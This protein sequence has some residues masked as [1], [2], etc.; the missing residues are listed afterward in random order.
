MN[1]ANN[2]ELF[3]LFERIAR[4][5]CDIRTLRTRG[6]DSLDFHDVSV[7]ALLDIM[8]AAYDAG[9]KAGREEGQSCGTVPLR[10]NSVLRFCSAFALVSLWRR[11]A[12]SR[13]AMIQSS[14][15]MLPGDAAVSKAGLIEGMLCLLLFQTRPIRAF[16][17]ASSRNQHGKTHPPCGPQR[18]EGAFRLAAMLSAKCQERGMKGLG[19][20]GR[21]RRWLPR[22]A[23]A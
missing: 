4:R 21:R 22:Q 11:S 12:S 17:P 23:A 2:P 15:A 13:I 1:Y 9:L 6:R 3:A 7:W 14:Q 5:R 8:Q 16:L 20:P 18:R 10:S 19:G